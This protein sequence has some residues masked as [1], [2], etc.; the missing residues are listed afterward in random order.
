MKLQPAPFEEIKRGQKTI[1]LR[2]YDEKR[3]AIKVGDRITF[4]NTE[5][6][7]TLSARVLK[8]HL[9]DSFAELYRA[10]P[11]LKCG[12]TTADIDTAAPADMD[13]Y[14]SAE[15]QAKYG[16]VGIVLIVETE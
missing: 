6:G 15:E 12:Y 4:T 11:L 10:L 3:R 5:S 8:L 2:L 1:E 16:V 9:F 7:E 13:A 14:Y